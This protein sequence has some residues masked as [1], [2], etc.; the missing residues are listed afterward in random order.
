ML[1]TATEAHLYTRELKVILLY[2]PFQKTHYPSL[3]TKLASLVKG[4]WIDGKAQTVAL[5]R[6][7][8]RH[9]H[10]FYSPNFSAVKTE[11]LH[12]VSR[13]ILIGGIYSGFSHMQN[14][15]RHIAA[16]RA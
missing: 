3:S 2:Q 1:R 5:L 10:L 13:I 12:Y 6:F 16:R 4:R 14:L 15:N 9:V 11:G 7:Y 8:L